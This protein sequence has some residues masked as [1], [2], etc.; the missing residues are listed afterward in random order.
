MAGLALS[1][2]RLIHYHGTGAAT[3]TIPSLSHHARDDD[4]AGWGRDEDSG[5]LLAGWIA[6]ETGHL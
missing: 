1:R 3:E 5:G 2:M 4:Q 6:P